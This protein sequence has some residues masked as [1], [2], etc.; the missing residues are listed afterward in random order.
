MTVAAGIRPQREP[1]DHPD[2]M[3]QAR[4]VAN[5]YDISVRTVDRWLAK[6]NFAFPKPVMVTHDALGRVCGRFWRLGDLI[7][8]ERRQAAP[9]AQA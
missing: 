5:R 6:P 7:D 9:H 8:W 1:V 4:S 2:L 3:M